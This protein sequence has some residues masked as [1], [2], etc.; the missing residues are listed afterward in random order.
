[1]I[2][3]SK[4]VLIIYD[5]E[6]EKSEAFKSSMFIYYLLDHFSVGSKEI[7]NIK[8]YK[9]G[10]ILGKDF[11]FVDFEDG[12]P[13][14]SEEFVLDLIKF[15]GEIIWLNMHIDRF[16][17]KA[18]GRFGIE[19]EG[20]KISREWKVIFNG[21]VF[22]KEDPG[23][24]LI[25][26]KEGK[27]VKVF[28]N[29]ID[30]DGNSFPYVIKT[31]NLWYFADS[32]FSFT[33]EGGRFLIFGELLHEILGEPHQKKHLALVRIEDV[34][35]EDNPKFLKKIGDYLYKENVPFQISLIPIYKN[36]EQQYEIKLS[37]NPTLVEAVK[38]MIEKG[39]TVVLH[40]VTHQLRGVTGEDYEFWDDISGKPISNESPDWVD[41][42]IKLGVSECIKNGIYPLA[43]ETPHYSA[44]KN[45]YRIISKY[46]STF[47][48]RIMSA[49]ISGTQQIFPYES[50][51]KD[52]RILLIPEN[53]GYVDFLKP[54]PEK[55]IENAKKMLVV[56]DGIASFF[57]HSFVPIRHL[58]RIVK[59][60]KKMGWEFV[61]LR[62]FPS[63]FKTESIWVTSKGG[64]GN[65]NLRNQFIHEFVLDRRGKLITESFSSRRHNGIFTKKLEPPSG[66]LYVVEGLDI[67]PEKRSFREF[68]Y[69][70]IERFFK[71]KSA[72]EAIKISNVLLVKSDFRRNEYRNDQD[73]YESVF[74]IFGLKP[75]IIEKDEII[76]TKIENFTILCVPHPSAINLKKEEMNEIIDFVEKGGILITDG[77]TPLSESF[78]ITFEN[79]SKEIREVKELSIP[80]PNLYWNPP[81]YLN[82]FRAN[83]AIILAKDAWS[84]QPVCILKPFKKGKVLFFGAEFD[85]FTPFGIARFPYFPVYLKNSLGIP[86]NG[87][88]NLLEFYFDPGLRQNVSLEKL[89]RRW[90]A[91]G[92]KIIYLAT[93]HFYR[94]YRFDY[95]YFI[96]LC[97]NFGISVYAWFEFPQVTPLFWEENPQWREKTATGEDAICHWRLLMNLYNPLC[98]EAVK[99]FFWKILMDYDWDGVNI[100]ELNFDTNKGANDPSKFTPM[101]EDVRR[102]FK[103][104]Y[105]FD[106]FELFNPKSPYFYKKNPSGY[107]KFLSF[108]KEITKN[109]HIYFLEEIEKIKKAKGKEMEVIITAMDSIIHPEIIEECGI[110]IKDI[111]SLMDRYPFTLQIEDP[112]RSWILPPIRYMNYFN[113]YKNFVKEKERLM[114]DINCI[115][116]RYISRT[117]LPS[118][119]V[120]GTELATTVYYALSGAGRA[121]I[122][123]EFTILPLDMDLLPFVY[124]SDVEISKDREKLLIKAKNPFVF[125]II[126]SEFAPYLNGEKWLF[127]G[128]KGVYIPSGQ[129]VLSFKKESGV[130][131]ALSHK[132]EFDGEIES[133]KREGNRFS[134]I[135]SSS[136]PVS[137]TFNRPLEEVK[138]NG[139]LLSIPMDKNGAVLP[140]GKHK[141]EIVP[142]SSYFYRIDII[143][144]LSSYIFYFIGF[145][146][147]TFLF[148]IYIYSKIKK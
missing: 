100:A 101:N 61:S 7:L 80:V 55:I 63:E 41:E 49:E 110:D 8:D 9:K 52:F 108:R 103:K 138:L 122:Y 37:D 95:K 31:K 73:S 64:I 123:S 136:L 21:E 94:N 56:R 106:P 118:P 96:E 84:E 20:F 139:F 1:N 58:K 11:I 90:K 99:D 116:R 141:L 14:F 53:L 113:V 70:R 142:T 127:Y 91:S 86:F 97:H 43:W 92:V 143:G 27:N 18:E 98:R 2:L 77:K 137:F 71:K 117:N 26:I 66:G 102:N 12:F 133:F 88:R 87:R 107:E 124:G 30:D 44:S 16:L 148:S 104:L 40:G 24:N 119:L 109:L 79:G 76:R 128:T 33:Y 69:E 140:R 111:I 54:E 121:G 68:I 85:P 38:Y 10:G 4:D 75:A 83:E 120:T 67:L 132:I 42:K 17:E 48:D 129:N 134:I 29:A 125:P 65:I 46:F 15:R 81:V 51:I 50:R 60:M 3:H 89:V 59:E 39:G 13:D 32:P 45:V 62:D 93:W 23:M 115:K 114:F 135:Y 145:I 78:G 112:S 131:M 105:R 74:K 35:P 22:T 126:P 47:N 130:E 36:P 147:V 6:R 5:G 146:S 82:K 25:K 28:T 57:F 19:Y 34:N 72:A 144:Y